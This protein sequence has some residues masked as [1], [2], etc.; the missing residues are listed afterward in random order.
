VV[1]DGGE[2]LSTRNFHAGALVLR[3]RRSG[4]RGALILEYAAHAAAGELSALA[5]PVTAQ[6]ASVGSGM[7][8]HASFAPLAAQ[9]AEQALQRYADALAAEIAV[10]VRAV[11]Q[12]AQAPRGTG[13]RALYA[14]TQQRLPSDVADRPLTEN[15]RAATELLIETFCSRWLKLA[16]I[17]SP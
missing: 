14:R 12:R 3:A 6:H 2:T 7:E 8:S 1:A 16:R 17:A 13:V 10:A 5:S 9:P 4:S 11:R 15:L